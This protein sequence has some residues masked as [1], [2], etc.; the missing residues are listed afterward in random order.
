MGERGLAEAGRPVEEGVVQGLVAVF[1]RIDGDAEVVL[2]LLLPDELVEAPGTQGDVEFFFV[3]LE[4]AGGNALGRRAGAPCRMGVLPGAII[5][6]C[7]IRV[8]ARMASHLGWTGEARP[9]F[10]TFLSR[11]FPFPPTGVEWGR[12]ESVMGAGQ[13]LKT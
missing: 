12:P 2:E 10:D 5:R 11:I 4:L 8:Y 6:S 13:P 9:S 1:R 7:G 3:I